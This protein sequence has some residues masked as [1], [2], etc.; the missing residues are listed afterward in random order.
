MPPAL[1]QGVVKALFEHRMLPRVLAGSSVG[2]IV[3]GIIATR[4]DDELVD[5]ITKMDEVRFRMIERRV[6]DSCAQPAA[7]RRGWA[8]LHAA[9]ARSRPAQAWRG[10]GLGRARSVDNGRDA[11]PCA[12]A[13]TPS[14]HN[15][16]PPS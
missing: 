2:S 6:C 14:P 1:T 16:R 11:T 8:C 7:G 15:P 9:P 3:A 10:T 12:W 13:L 5:M 4:T